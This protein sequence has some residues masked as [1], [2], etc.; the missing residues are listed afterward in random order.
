MRDYR[1]ISADSFMVEGINNKLKWL[2]R[3][4]RHVDEHTDIENWGSA[5]RTL[6]SV[7]SLFLDTKS[8]DTS[9]WTKT[10]PNMRKEFTISSPTT[11]SCT[12]TKWQGKRKRVP[13][14]VLLK[15]PNA[16]VKRASPALQR[17]QETFKEEPSRPE[18]L[19][20]TPPSVQLDESPVVEAT[21]HGE[22][23]SCNEK[24]MKMRSRPPR[25]EV[26][27]DDSDMLD[28]KAAVMKMLR[29][30]KEQPEKSMLMTQREI[31]EVLTELASESEE[32]MISTEWES[33]RIG[34]YTDSEKDRY[35]YR[36]QRTGV[37]CWE[38]PTSTK[39]P[40]KGY[41]SFPG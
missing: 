32:K 28:P 4:L 29:E 3:R 37:S 15:H 2:A 22:K 14:T 33:W 36:N 1:G 35:W 10:T 12:G 11:I 25:V 7:R 9:T 19:L 8:T 26:E 24:K 17:T 6:E 30:A 16:A 18:K 41:R 5:I 40:C 21:S 34:R 23:L 39:I 20:I 38:R 31:N 27:R 13:Q